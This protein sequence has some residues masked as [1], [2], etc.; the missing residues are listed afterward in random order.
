[1]IPLEQRFKEAPETLQTLA[2]FIRFAISVMATEDIAFGQGTASAEDEAFYLVLRALKLP[3]SPPEA[4]MAARLLPSEK[5][6]LLA[7][8]EKR[9]GERI[10]TAYLLNEAWFCQHRFYVDEHGI[11]PRSFI[12][13]ILTKYWQDDTFLS[14]F[15]PDTVLDLCT[16]SGC[17]AILAA[18]TFP[19]AKIDAVDL[20]KDALA[21]ARKNIALYGFEDKI[22]LI[23]SDL[24]QSIPEKR[25]DLI[26]CNPPYVPDPLMEHLP[27][28]FLKEPPM[29][30]AGG[31][32]GLDLICRIL[33]EAPNYL[34]EDGLLLL[35][36]GGLRER[37][38]AL[39][40]HTPFYWVTT[41][42]EDSAVCCL[43][44]KDLQ[45]LETSMQ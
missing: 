31:Q 17:L 4:L 35:E 13:E 1:M 14:A 42:T 27:P 20:S 5:T 25:Y 22:H 9:L 7:L 10:P 33:K 26:L 16:G 34:Q 39:F 41:T 2:D 36:V 45:D 18:L 6:Q 12:G 30:F 38:E 24:F 21:V 29:A 11:I 43:S 23:C 44:Q 19:S 32:E 40:P 37:L 3:F 28:E 8:L 15:A